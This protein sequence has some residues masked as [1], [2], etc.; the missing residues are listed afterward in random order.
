MA[1]TGNLLHVLH[2]IHVFLIELMINF[3]LTI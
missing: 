1:T 3:L 2:V